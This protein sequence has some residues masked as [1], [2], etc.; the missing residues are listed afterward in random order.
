MPS[1]RIDGTLR[2]ILHHIDLATEFAG[3]LDRETFSADLRTIYAVTRCL[4]IISEASRRVPEELKASHP[5]IAWKQMAAAGNVY[6]HNYEDVAA[7]L[8]WETVQRALPPLK[9]V[10]QDEIARLQ[11]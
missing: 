6:R 5:A 10:V 9:A 8:V 1:D 4:E 7:H 11:G 2:D 3:D